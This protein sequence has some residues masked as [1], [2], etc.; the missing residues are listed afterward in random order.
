MGHASDDLRKEHEGILFGLRIL[1]QMVRRL[2]AGPA[3]DVEQLKEMVGFLQLFA[4]RC[5]HGK[6]EGLY[7]PS[8]EK[9]GIP[10]EGGPIGQMLREHAMGR[11]FVARMAAAVESPYRPMEFANAANG[12]IDLLRAHI[13]KENDVLFRMGDARLP[14]E[15]QARLLEA[16]ETFEETVMGPGV[17][18]RLHAMLDRYEEIYLA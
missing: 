5:H 17:H 12:Y 3:P 2:K 13:G 7:F 18:E 14:P 9:V 11:V 1:E 4:D 10:N 15:E 8:L 16:F 6:E